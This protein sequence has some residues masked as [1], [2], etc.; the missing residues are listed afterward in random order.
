MAFK[1]SCIQPSDFYVLCILLYKSF[2]SFRLIITNTFDL[3]ASY[4]SP[5]PALI[6][7]WPRNANSLKIKNVQT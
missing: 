6:Y 4:L 5:F 7:Q 1:F 2:S 3:A